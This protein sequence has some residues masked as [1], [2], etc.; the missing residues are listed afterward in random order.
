MQQPTTLARRH[1][2]ALACPA[3][4]I[5]VIVATAV[6]VL[7]NAAVVTATVVVLVIIVRGADA[8]PMSRHRVVIVVKGLHIRRFF[9]VRPRPVS[10]GVG[11][12]L[13]VNEELEVVP[14]GEVAVRFRCNLKVPSICIPVQR[15]CFSY[16][17]IRSHS[18]VGSRLEEW[19]TKEVEKSLGDVAMGGK[20][21]QDSF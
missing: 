12:Q 11:V 13:P 15:A 19:E 14:V 1:L 21:K 9:V 16:A 2:I 20:L 5:A 6:A 3:I 7:V 4:I 10:A 17:G 8:H 18:R